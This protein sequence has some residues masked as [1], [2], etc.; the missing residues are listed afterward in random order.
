MVTR[1]ENEVIISAIA[2]AVKS[3]V[4]LKLSGL[5]IYSKIK[6]CVRSVESMLHMRRRSEPRLRK[7]KKLCKTKA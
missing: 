1:G 4:Q 6:F 7:P 5:K 2:V 3:Q